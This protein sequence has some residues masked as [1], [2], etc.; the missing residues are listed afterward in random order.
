MQVDGCGGGNATKMGVTYPK[1]GQFLNDTGRQILYTCS[2]PVY[3]SL[4]KGCGGHLT[5]EECFPLES[6]VESCSTWRVYKD[7]MD[8]YNAP[9][10]H[11]GVRQLIL[12]YARNNATLA[13]ASGPG[14]F[15]D[16]D[17]L[18]GGDAGLSLPEAK[19]QFSM[20]SMFAAPLLMSNDLRAISDDMVSMLTN[21]EV[22]PRRILW[23][24]N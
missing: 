9:E 19:I 17:M 8:V 7:I 15:N 12:F 16:Y 6:I 22:R 4:A 5:K 23:L 18:L 24:K 10:P 11:S 1:L 14:H 13:K 21:K 20:W 3:T 2:W